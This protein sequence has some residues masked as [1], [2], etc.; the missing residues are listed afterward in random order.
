MKKC[1]IPAVV[2]IVLCSGCSRSPAKHP[3]FVDRL[4]PVKTTLGM[5]Q[6][7]NGR[8]LTT[9][10]GLRALLE[11]PNDPSIT[12]WHGPYVA[13]ASELKDFWGRDYVYRCPGIHNP[14]GYDLYSMGPDG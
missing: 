1:I 14:N 5:F 2:G 11:K 7:D 12:N 13:K 6:V 3:R 8:Y 10:E 9:A 4:A